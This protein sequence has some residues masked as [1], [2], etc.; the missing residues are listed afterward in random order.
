MPFFLSL[1]PFC[2]ANL[3]GEYVGRERASRRILSARPVTYPRAFIHTDNRFWQRQR[4]ADPLVVAPTNTSP[5]PPSVRL[6]GYRIAAVPWLLP[7]VESFAHCFR[8]ASGSPIELVSRASR[9]PPIL[10]PSFRP[11]LVNLPGN[12]SSSFMERVA[13]KSYYPR[14]VSPVELGP[15]PLFPFDGAP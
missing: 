3:I 14:P 13:L 7:P 6:R 2:L 4:R 12:C 15:S 10:L 1:L 11:L 8:D 9:R 5:C